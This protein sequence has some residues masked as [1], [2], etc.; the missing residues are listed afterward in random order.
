M[1][2]GRRPDP[3]AQPASKRPTERKNDATNAGHQAGVAGEDAEEE[4]SEQRERK[5]AQA[6]V[7][8]PQCGIDMHPR[9]HVE[10][11]EEPRQ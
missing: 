7:R 4:A 11:A 10:A 1:A 6:H 3:Q 9:V 5:T 2:Y 8:E